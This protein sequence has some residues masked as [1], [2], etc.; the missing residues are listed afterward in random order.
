M[1]TE[2]RPLPHFRF[3]PDPLATGAIEES[4][5][6]CY[7]CNKQTGYIYS[8]PFYASGGGYFCPWCIASGEAAKKYDG[9]FQL[10]TRVEFEVDE[11]VK[12]SDG[13]SD[14]L[15]D[16]KKCAISEAEL[17]ELV[18]RTPGYHA[19]QRAEWLVHCS[20]PC[21]FL[22]YVRWKEIEERLD[23]FIDLEGDANRGIG[24]SLDHLAW[25][26]SDDEGDIGV[27]GYLF[28]C[29]HCGGFR[30]HVDRD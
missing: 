22:G 19:W 3:H 25:L 11:F 27:G 30:L 7:V 24:V 17:S 26:L 21:A 29:I 8:R 6:E 9:E 12:F 28:Q 20:S 23:K 18:H 13:S 5:K 15:R 10:S 4:E 16:A 14:F 2:T 1:D